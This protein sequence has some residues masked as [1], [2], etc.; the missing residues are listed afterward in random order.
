MRKGRRVRTLRGSI[1]Q[2]RPATRSGQ[3]RGRRKRLMTAAADLPG[4]GAG[5]DSWCFCG[6]LVTIRR[7][8]QDRN[9]PDQSRRARGH[10]PYRRPP[11]LAD[12]IAP[13]ILQAADLGDDETDGDSHA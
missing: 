10:D 3:G 7:Y 8:L 12:D 4:P 9:H 13:A 1:W 2:E 5:R 6:C 11:E